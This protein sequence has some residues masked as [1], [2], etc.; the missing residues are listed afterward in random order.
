[1]KKHLLKFI[2]FSICM[3]G[4]AVSSFAQEIEN[5]GI[6]SILE[7][8]QYNRAIH[9]MAMLLIGFGFLMV[10]VKKY[11]RSA[12]TATFL[13][14]SVSIPLYLAVKSMGV[15]H[16]TSEIQQFILAEFGAASLL[17]AAGAILGRIK[18]Y[19]YMILGLL[20]IPFYIFNEFIVLDDHFNFIGTIADTGGSIVI[21]AF[22]AIFGISAAISLTTKAHRKIPIEAD[23]T[24]DRFSLLGSMILWVFWPSFCAALVPVEA[25]P[26][27][28]VNVFIA[29]C[30]STIATYIASVKIRGKINAADIANAAL[31]GGVA[32]GATCDHAS[33]GEAMIIGLIAGAISTIGFA[34]F[35]AKQEKFHKIIDTCGVSNLHGIPGIFGGFAAIL[36]VDGIDAAAQVKGIVITILI[37]IVSGLITG[38][39]VSLFGKTDKIYDDENEFE[40]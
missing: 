39:V 30:G 6:S 17:I 22:G 12:I 11:G 31:A 19:Q 32:I 8:Q 35:Q 23:A 9:I 29:L 20:F 4:T 27:T 33:H 18:M 15:F 7:I 16:Q 1:M 40:D 36:V 26:H 24:S 2:V 5:T 13:L 38:K 21:H 10:F 37:A 25:I 3:I 14:V 34:I 28:V